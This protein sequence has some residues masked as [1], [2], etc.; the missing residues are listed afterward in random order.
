MNQLASRTATLSEEITS[1]RLDGESRYGVAAVV[2]MNLGVDGTTVLPRRNKTGSIASIKS[3]FIY[4]SRQ[5]DRQV[6]IGSSTLLLELG[7]DLLELE[8]HLQVHEDDH[9]DAV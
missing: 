7:A 1:R 5:T 6:S 3:L 4:F 2:D 8:E 9:N